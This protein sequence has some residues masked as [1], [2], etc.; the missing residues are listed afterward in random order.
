MAIFPYLFMLVLVVTFTFLLCAGLEFCVRAGQW[1]M[2]L[3]DFARSVKPEQAA[4]TDGG[5]EV[6]D[7]YPV[8]GQQP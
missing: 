1:F 8:S 3:L 6:K 7:D 5:F 4:M 2:D